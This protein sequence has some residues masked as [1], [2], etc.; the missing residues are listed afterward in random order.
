MLPLKG[1]QALFQVTLHVQGVMSNSQWYHQ[2]RCLIKYE[3][4]SNVY[5]FKIEYFR[6]WFFYWRKKYKNYLIFTILNLE[7]R[8]YL[9][10]IEQIK[11]Y[12]GTIVVRLLP[13]QHGGSLLI[14]LLFLH[15]N[16]EQYG[17]VFLIQL[18]RK[19]RISH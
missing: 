8:Q 14:S 4:D 9:N 3:L 10:I 16:F 13:S 11:V 5:N 17:I 7:K 18:S 6:L 15:S 19:I 12:K 1:L 2:K